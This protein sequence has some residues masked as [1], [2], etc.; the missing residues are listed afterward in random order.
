MAGLLKVVLCSARILLVASVALFLSA[1]ATAWARGVVR[2]RNGRPISEAAVALS[3]IGAS[4]PSVTSLSEANGCFSVV[5]P[6]RRGQASFL[7]T[8]KASGYKEVSVSFPR[9]ERLTATITLLA[10]T[11]PGTSTAARLSPS[12]ESRAY[13]EPCIPVSVPDATRLGIR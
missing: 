9:R 2:D 4:S 8:V 7:L 1:C 3:A 13:E 10:E 11:Q 12:E 6:A 5:A